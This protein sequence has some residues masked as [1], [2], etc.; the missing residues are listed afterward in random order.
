[1]ETVHAPIATPE[2]FSL[3]GNE[4]LP[5]KWWAAFDD[6]KLNT[7]ID[8]ALSANLNLAATWEQFKV[9]TAIRRRQK[10]FLWPD[11]EAGS[12]N[13]FS[14]PE[15]DF[16]GGE[17]V[18]LG[19]S[20]AYEIDL[21]GRIHSAAQAAD[22]RMQATYYDYQAAAISLSANIAS[23]YFQLI[24]A[25]R[26]LEVANN[27][28]ATNENSLRLIG[29]RFVGGQIRAVDI[30]RQRQLLEDTRNQKLIYEADVALLNNQLAV[31][32]GQPPQNMPAVSV[33]SLPKLPALPQT[34]LPLELVR[35]RP[36]VVQAYNLVLAA[37]RDMAEA[38]RNKYP[39]ISL[40]LS[41]QARSNNYADL[42]KEWA[43]T[44][45]GNLVAPLLYG[46][47]LRAEV[48]RTEALK[49]QQLYVYGQT[50]LTAFRE[51]EDALINEQIQKER[52]IIL[53]RQL[54]LAESTNGQLRLEFL[55][56]L[57]D[58]LDVL[59]ALDQEQQLRRDFID[60]QQ[61]QLEIRI[62]MYRALA[63]S[64]EAN[65]TKEAVSQ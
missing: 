32:V 23:I 26:Q 11:I 22:F 51:V 6:P 43:Y 21:W 35:R 27:Q 58:Y 48:D 65:G 18:Q 62:N 29:A 47:R 9:A 31:L 16:A 64:F 17:N 46:G 60:A 57:S 2:N 8:S 52:L 49:N 19:L 39:R 54:D 30:L 59:L 28:I 50:V 24:T 7:L 44:L 61:E 37:D 1:M 55:N 13:A 33:D 36:D 20:A 15:P 40:S 63:G 25:T 38:V 5:Q 42:F 41:A 45:A 14:R 53:A 4:A 34:G 56:G 10:S 3:T 12:Q